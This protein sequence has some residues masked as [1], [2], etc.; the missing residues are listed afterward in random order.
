MH[1]LIIPSEQFL[2]P[3]NKMDGIF[4]HH[5]ATILKEDGHRVGVLSVSLNFSVPM[6]VKGVFFKLLRKKTGNA[7]DGIS[8]GKLL[9]LGF[10]KFF[11][12]RKYVSK[13][14]ID[15]LM[16]YRVDGLYFRPPVQNQN[17]ISWIKAG[18]TCFQEYVKQEG[19]PD[20]IHAHNA[21]YAG[22]LA[23]KI[24]ETNGIKYIITEHSSIYALEQVNQNTLQLARQAYDKASGLFAV[25]EAFAAYLNG[26]HSFQRFRYLPNVLDQKLENYPY[27]PTKESNGKFVF[28]HIASFIDVK[29]QSTLLSAFKKVTSNLPGTELWIGGG[30]EL[31]EDLKQQ[32]KDLGIQ[33]SVKF[34]GLL[35]R[36]E[37]I[38]NIQACDSFVLSSK[39]ETFGVVVIESM[40]FGKPVIVT[41]CG[42]GQS[43]VNDKIGYVVE[44]GNADGLADA[45]LK[46]TATHSR[47]DPD[48]I[49]NYTINS[50]GKNAFSEQ[51]NKI[52]NEVF[53]RNKKKTIHHNEPLLYNHCTKSP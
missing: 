18:M 31:E 52:Y 45:M 14:V 35:N 27:R 34:M 47:F 28:L 22:M 33:N 48:Y 32:V 24:F 8:I 42:V 11:S 1:I 49:R 37:V 7:T 38:K 3:H 15:G 21:V 23:Q 19:R 30:G 25:S 16:V 29:D 13:E 4:Q 6:V 17:H 36:D 44:V 5:Q 2:P 53:N 10:T 43:I 26:L 12:P 46:M 39:Y 20:I 51:V 40:L 9:T 50:F 41:R